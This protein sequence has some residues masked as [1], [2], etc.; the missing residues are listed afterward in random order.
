M[1]LSKEHAGLQG[2]PGGEI[3]INNLMYCR[4]TFIALVAL[5][6]LT[7]LGIQNKEDVAASIA[8]VAMGLAGANAFEK[9][10]KK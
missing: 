7:L 10:E 3:T 1:I 4:R 2:Q 6:C 5:G 9:K 8:A